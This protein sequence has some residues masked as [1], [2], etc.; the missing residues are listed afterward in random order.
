MDEQVVYRVDLEGIQENQRIDVQFLSDQVILNRIPWEVAS[1]GFMTLDL[2]SNRVRPD[3]TLRSGESVLSLRTWDE[4]DSGQY[5]LSLSQ[6]DLEKLWRPDL[7]PGMP[8]GKLS[9]TVDYKRSPEDN[10]RLATDI[11]ILQA[12]YAGIHYDS[13]SLTGT[14][15][16]R[17][18]SNLETELLVRMDSSSMEM[19]GQRSSENNL[20]LAAGFRRFPLRTIEPLVNKYISGLQGEFS[21]DFNIASTPQGPVYAGNVKLNGA[22]LKVNALN[23]RFTIPD[24]QLRIGD[25]NILFDNFRILDTLNNA[26]TVN[27]TVYIKPGKP[28]SARLEVSSDRLKLMSKDPDSQAPITGDIFLDSRF[29]IGGPL[30]KPN[31]DGKILLSHGTEIYFQLLENLNTSE[32]A[33]IVDFTNFTPA[34]ADSGTV[35]DVH[36]LNFIKSSIET[37]VE[38]DPAT[39]LNFRVSRRIYD[40]E[41]NI[42]GGGQ[43]DYTLLDNNRSTLSG[44]Y[45]IREG[46]A[47]LKLTGWPNKEFTITQGGY[48]RWDGRIDNPELKIEAM[49]RVT[50]SYINPVD[51]KRMNADFNVIL[52]MSG[53]LSDLDVR[54]VVRTPDQYIMSVINTLSPEEQMQQAV[55]ILLFETIDLPGVSSSSNYMTQQINQMLATQLNQLTQSTIKGFDISFGFDS[56]NQPFEGGTQKTK[57]NLTYEVRKSMLNER[58]QFELKGRVYDVNQH[59]GSSDISLHDISFEYRLDSAATKYLKVY[60]KQ[61]YDDVFEGQVVK[62]GIGYTY[63]RRYE[64]L[65][66]IWRRKKKKKNP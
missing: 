22:G 33:Q 42:K 51:G 54:F 19:E 57:T 28:A 16:L 4:Q 23:S 44:R 10:M 20:T 40:L 65:S 5:R 21:G 52:E 27:G 53:Y 7:I 66:D 35:L 2:G 59:P 14:L 60:N 17:G 8:A 45:E 36:Q 61:S 64:S 62:T 63:R 47:Y 48:V 38:I 43:V 29:S 32:S 46:E 13:I 24:Q 11:Q 34:E 49:N 55:S 26:L 1:P 50:S 31:I 39:L 12:A 41:M 18:E 37:S 15:D 3:F 56:Y 58:A 6:V 30:S 9:G 25:D